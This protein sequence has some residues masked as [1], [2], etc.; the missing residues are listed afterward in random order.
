MI[1]RIQLLTTEEY[2]NF[3]KDILND[4]FIKTQ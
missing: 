1:D 2:E 4:G 3:I